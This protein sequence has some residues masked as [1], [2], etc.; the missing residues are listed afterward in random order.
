MNKIVLEVKNC[1]KCP[2]HFTT[3]Y[4]TADSWEKAEYYW[5]RCPSIKTETPGRD[6]EGEVARLQ[7][8][9]M[10]EYEK[11]SY[12]AGYVEWNDKIDIPNE[13]PLVLQQSDEL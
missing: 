5:C 8:K 1:T 4:P 13:C 11:L 6:K 3:P 9:K 2:H 7:I 12:V 10:G